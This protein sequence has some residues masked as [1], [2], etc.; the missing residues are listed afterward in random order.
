MPGDPAFEG[1]SAVNLPARLLALTWR[2][3]TPTAGKQATSGRHDALQAFLRTG[4]IGAGVCVREH[5]RRVPDV[6]VG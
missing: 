5:G 2:T 3:T 4:E 1:F 6:P